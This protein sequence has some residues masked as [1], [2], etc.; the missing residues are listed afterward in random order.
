MGFNFFAMG[1]GG[2]W[3]ELRI[4]KDAAQATTGKEKEVENLKGVNPYKFKRTVYRHVRFEMLED[5]T[6]ILLL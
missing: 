2:W 5:W 4:S 6:Y 1:G 3:F